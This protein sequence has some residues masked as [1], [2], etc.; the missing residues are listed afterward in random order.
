MALTSLLHRSSGQ[1]EP[2]IFM[3]NI[4][5][6]L[7]MELTSSKREGVHLALVLYWAV[8]PCEAECICILLYLPCRHLVVA[9]L[10]EQI[11]FP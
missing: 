3:I 10:C 1:L 5:T 7:E 4:R 6:K 2:R 11:N 9:N 8:G